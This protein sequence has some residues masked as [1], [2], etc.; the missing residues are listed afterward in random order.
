MNETLGFAQSERKEKNLC[1]SEGFKLNTLLTKGSFKFLILTKACF[2]EMP[3]LEPTQMNGV[4]NIRLAF[5]CDNS[6]MCCHLLATE[7]PAAKNVSSS[8]FG[9]GSLNSVCQCG[10]ISEITHFYLFEG[11]PHF[12][13]RSSHF[14]H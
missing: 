1:A 4:R 10:S 9:V 3:S 14:L 6:L 8:I 7:I 5:C 11:I 2:L 13:N 12:P